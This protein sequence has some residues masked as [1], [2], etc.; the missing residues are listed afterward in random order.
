MLR[1]MDGSPATAGWLCRGYS[2]NAA[3]TAA[4]TRLRPALAGLRRGKQIAEFMHRNRLMMR[5]R[6]NLIDDAQQPAR[7]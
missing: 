6:I 7:V 1:V 4:T 3:G 2:E 5:A